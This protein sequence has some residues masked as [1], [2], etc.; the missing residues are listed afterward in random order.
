ME[1]N[2]TK[3][4]PAKMYEFAIALP[5]TVKA[6]TQLNTLR[7]KNSDSVKEQ[8][9]GNEVRKSMEKATSSLDVDAISPKKIIKEDVIIPTPSNLH[10]PG[11]RYL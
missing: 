1:I 7:S 11:A 5:Q 3:V 10:I 9:D 8:D 4:N 2:A 6:K